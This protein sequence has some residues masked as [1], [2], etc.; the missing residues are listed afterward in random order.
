[1]KRKR[2]AS[3]TQ[4]VELYQQEK[5]DEVIKLVPVLAHHKKIS[6]P[7]AVALVIKTA[8]RLTECGKR[9]KGKWSSQLE[10]W[11]LSNPSITLLKVPSGRFKMGDDRFNWSRPA[12]FVN[13]DSFWLSECC[14]TQTQWNFVARLPEVATQLGKFDSAA[15]VDDGNLPATGMEWEEVVEFCNRLFVF[16]KDDPGN[17][18]AVEEVWVPGEAQWEYACRAGTTGDYSLTKAEINEGFINCMN[19]AGKYA[20]QWAVNRNIP[21]P[22]GFYN[23]HGNVWEWCADDWRDDYSQSMANRADEIYTGN[24]EH[25]NVVRGGSASSD[26]GCCTSSYRGRHLKKIGS[27]SVGFRIQVKAN[28]KTK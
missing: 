12:H 21:N 14:I 2:R 23:M 13:L 22:W 17:S 8:N 6:E 15:T 19:N 27:L 3:L 26:I 20:G 10:K 25:Y 24:F 18:M 5:F 28:P 16:L 11:T 7:E 4:L 1:M 9:Q